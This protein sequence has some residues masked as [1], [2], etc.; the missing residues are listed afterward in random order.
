MVLLTY[1]L[2]LLNLRR[3]KN[4]FDDSICRDW[5]NAYNVDKMIETIASRAKVSDFS[6]TI[7]IHLF[8]EPQIYYD[9]TPVQLR[10]KKALALVAYLV[11]TGKT[12]PRERV[13]TL[14]WPDSS[15]SVAR[16]SLR[17]AIQAIKQTPLAS[18][19]KTTRDTI[20]L[21]EEVQS[22]VK[23]FQELMAYN[24][25]S[26]SNLSTEAVARL[27]TAQVLY[28]G[29]FLAGFLVPESV[30]WEDWQGFRQIEFNQQ[31]TETVSALTRHYLLNNLPNSGL[32]MVR[33]WLDM[34]SL[35]EEAH[36]FALHLYMLAGQAE[37]A[38]EQYHLLVRIL[39]REQHRLPDEEIQQTYSQI[40]QGAYHT[41]KHKAVKPFQKVVRSLLPK[42]PS[43]NKHFQQECAAIYNLL[44]TNPSASLIVVQ[45]SAHQDT[46]KLISYIAYNE[47]T[48][49]F[50][51]DGI[52]WA[53]L[54][55][56]DDFEAVLRLWMD[57]M[58]ISVLKSTSKLEHLAWQFHNGLRGKR[59]LFLLE[60]STSTQQV[61]LILPAYK[62]C[63]LIATTPQPATAEALRPKADLLLD[64]FTETQF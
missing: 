17:Q 5:R 7:T 3:H 63:V 40:R 51:P 49:F 9:Q 37:R 56:E 53:A 11:T 47:R 20:S 43:P 55:S 61:E 54:E 12:H 32:K 36:H 62:G 6:M 30:E 21:S 1:P 16:T 46:S 29:E 57:A 19:L 27:Q 28:K 48:K 31:I 4:K 34:D 41:P 50:F 18:V 42:P 52:L 8:G 35:N 25:Y 59:L 26:R 64:I 33:W 13:A 2:V 58:R 60:G 45:D 38:I 15:A 10:M 22:D 23:R 24:D 39:E 44:H 14:L